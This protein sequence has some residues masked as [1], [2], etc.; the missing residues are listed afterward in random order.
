MSSII[1]VSIFLFWDGN[2][3]LSRSTIL[4]LGIIIKKFLIFAMKLRLSLI[5][6]D[7][8]GTAYQRLVQIPF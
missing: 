6:R 7:A 1:G 5:T 3:K 4:D 2:C 8:V